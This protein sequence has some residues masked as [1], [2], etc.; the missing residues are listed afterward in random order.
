MWT[1]PFP[2]P[3]APRADLGGRSTVCAWREFRERERERE[4]DVWR[5]GGREEGEM[6]RGSG[7]ER[8]REREREGERQGSIAGPARGS[9]WSYVGDL[10]PHCPGA[11]RRKPAVSHC[12]WVL[13]A[14]VPRQR[15]PVATR[16][17]HMLLC[18]ERQ[19][20]SKAHDH[21]QDG[22]EGAPGTALAP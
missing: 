9:S 11:P 19:P 4:G 22:V 6:E 8:E 16:Q 1:P 10:H 3:A 17:G 5:E 2:P 15:I 7:R 18:L 21:V 12:V 13:L 14:A 20:P